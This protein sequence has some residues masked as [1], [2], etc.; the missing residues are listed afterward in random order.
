MKENKIIFVTGATSGF[1]LS[2]A[3][4]LVSEGHKVYGTS[5]NPSKINVRL[6]FEL[7]QLDVTSDESVK[8]CI[9]GL[10][11]KAPTIDVVV[12]NAGMAVVGAIEETSI[13]QAKLQLET[14]FWGSVRVTKEILPVLR[15]QRQGHIINIGSLAGLIG[16]PFQG[17]YSASKHALEGYTK[18][19]RFE[20]EPFN[21]KLTLIEPGFFRTNL[22]H[23]SVSAA[24][25]VVDYDSIRPKVLKALSDSIE[26]APSPEI[27]AN[28]VSKVLRS[29][30]PKFK[31]RVGNDSKFLPILNFFF[32]RLFE[33]GAKRKFHLM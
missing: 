33:F 6:D 31:Y 12:N 25:K 32:P 28:L 17:F 5:R 26:H 15:R 3:N 22:Q 1:G 29:K 19:L 13:D 16:V 10:L 2:I 21:I 24:E 27:V 9:Q 4:R 8:R 30:N 18:S 7:L 14:N 23:S 20:L 11:S